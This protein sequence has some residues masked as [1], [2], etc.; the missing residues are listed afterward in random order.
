MNFNGLV[1]NLY[2]PQHPRYARILV[3][4]AFPRNTYRP[5][6]ILVLNTPLRTTYRPARIIGLIAL[7]RTTSR[8]VRING[9]NRFPIITYRYARIIVFIGIPLSY[10]LIGLDD[11]VIRGFHYYCMMC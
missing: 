4:I 11:M 3:L 2:V 10:S 7:L 9:V 6:R 8:H 5:A 1:I